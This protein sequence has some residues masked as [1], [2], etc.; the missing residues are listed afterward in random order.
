MSV[1]LEQKSSGVNKKEVSFT[2]RSF[3]SC[4]PKKF[5]S[6]PLKQW[7]QLEVPTFLL[8]FGNFSEANLGF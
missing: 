2:T 3:I 4:T 5:N 1:S 7:C 6:S 8:G